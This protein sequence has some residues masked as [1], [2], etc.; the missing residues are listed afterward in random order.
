MCTQIEVT[1]LD[2]EVNPFNGKPFFSEVLFCHTPS[3]T[4]MITDF[5]WNWPADA[6]WRTR[7]FNWG[8]DVLFKPFYFNYM[9]KDP[10]I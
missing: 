4:C 9:I 8:M 6:P 2:F 3:K 5:F 7:T 1:H 10:G